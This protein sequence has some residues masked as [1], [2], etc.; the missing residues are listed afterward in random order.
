MISRIRNH[1]LFHPVREAGWIRSILRYPKFFMTWRRYQ[2]MSTERV[3]GRD[4]YP[5]LFD[6]TAVTEFDPH[7]FYQS[8][9]AA[10]AIAKSRVRLHVDVGSQINLI[11]PLTGFV[12]VD[13]VD[14]RPLVAELPNLRSVKGSVLSLPYEDRSVKSLSSL[15]VIEHIGLGRYGDPLDPEGTLK[16]CKELQRVLA[17]KG[18]LYVSMPIGKQ[19]VAFNG[20]RIHD[21]VTILGYFDQLHL[22][23]FSSIDDGGKQ[24]VCSNPEE[25]RS[26]YYGMGFFHFVRK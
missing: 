26:W 1:R 20:H 18:H 19:R 3:S 2:K 13:F 6:S 22:A 4:L 23:A 16:A 17:K 8:A 10:E 14:I 15:H 24:R 7:Y 11:A 12:K 21:P 25:C 9:W 5:C